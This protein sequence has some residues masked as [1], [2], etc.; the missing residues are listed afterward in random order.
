RKRG[1][2]NTLNGASHTGNSSRRTTPN[3]RKHATSP[4]P[5]SPSIKRRLLSHTSK[6]ALILG[7][8]FKR[9][10]SVNIRT[11]NLLQRRISRSSH[12]AHSR[13]ER[14][15]LPASLL[16]VTL[17]VAHATRQIKRAR[18]AG[19]HIVNKPLNRI[20]HTVNN[21]RDSLKRSPC[22][23]CSRNNS[24]VLF[25][26]LRYSLKRRGNNLRRRTNARQRR[27]E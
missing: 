2:T 17:H 25:H 13:I 11:A 9:Q 8:L 24:R 18:R 22:A 5:A 26:K 27:D 1:S 6:L 15:N 14:G 12:D 7:I 21:P 23:H 16:K 10:T 19:L 20:F 3:G 4:V